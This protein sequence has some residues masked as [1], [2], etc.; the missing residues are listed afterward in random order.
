MTAKIE[1]QMGKISAEK[2]ALNRFCAEWL[3]KGYRNRRHR[4]RHPGEPGLSRHS[5]PWEKISKEGR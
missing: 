2:T 5:F 1:D 3:L 4:K